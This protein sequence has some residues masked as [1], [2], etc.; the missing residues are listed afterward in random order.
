M[1]TVR[2]YA[3]NCLFEK[4]LP[5]NLFYGD[6]IDIDFYGTQMVRIEKFG[7]LWLVTDAMNGWGDNN[8]YEFQDA[9]VEVIDM[10]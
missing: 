3:H 8:A 7:N 9:I 6:L 4:E 5:D 1:K 2:I 10:L